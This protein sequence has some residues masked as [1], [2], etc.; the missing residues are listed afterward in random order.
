MVTYTA[1]TW[2][3]I[4]DASADA[5]DVI[6]LQTAENGWVD[7]T[8]QDIKLMM[9]APELLKTLE[10]ILENE[11]QRS[12]EEWVDHNKPSGDCEQI[13]EQWLKSN[14]FF[15]FCAAWSAEYEVVRM[16]K[17]EQP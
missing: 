7:A 2:L 6:R 8:E 14:A 17:G 9:L 13:T 16:A 10:K 3:D 4:A 5:P 1:G 15:D 12:F 11:N